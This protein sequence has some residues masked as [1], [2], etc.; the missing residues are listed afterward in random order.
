MKRKWG[1]LIAIL[2]VL[3]AVFPLLGAGLDFDVNKPT[4]NDTV[5]T[6]PGYIRETRS[7]VYDFAVEEHTAAGKHA[8][9][10]ATT[11]GLSEETYSAG[12]LIFNSTTGALLYGNGSAWVATNGSTS[13]PYALISTYSG[14]LTAAIAA[15][16]TS[17]KTLLVVDTPATLSAHTTL[18]ANIFLQFIGAGKVSLGAYNLTLTGPVYAP[19]VQV[20]DCSGA[21]RVLRGT[22]ET[23]RMVPEWWGAVADGTTNDYAAFGLALA[24]AGTTYDSAL[25]LTPGKVYM[26][27]DNLLTIPA[28][29]DVLFNAGSKLKLLNHNIAFY[30]QIQ[31]SVRPLFVYTGTGVAVTGTA[32]FTCESAWFPTPLPDAISFAD[33]NQTTI[34]VSTTSLTLDCTVPATAVLQIKKGN[35]ISIAT[36]KTLALNNAPE[37][38]IYAIFACVGTGKVTMPAFVQKY[39]DWWGAVGNGATDDAVPLQAWATCGGNLWLPFKT[40][41]TATAITVPDDAVIDGQGTLYQTDD[42]KEGFIVK[43]DV[44]IRNISITGA[45]AAYGGPNY[46][47]GIIPYSFRNGSG[48]NITTGAL[49]LWASGNRMLI[50]N[51]KFTAWDVAV[52]AGLDSTIQNCTATDNWREAFYFGGTGGRALYN[53]V[54]G[55][56]SWAIDFNGGDSQAIGNKIK[57]CGRVLADGGGIVF[58]GMTTEKPMTR[59][60]ASLNEIYDC[61]VGYGIIVLSKATDGVWGDINISL[62]K[63]DGVDTTSALFGIY[64]YVGTASTVTCKNLTVEGNVISN[65]KHMLHGVYLEGGSISGNTG[66][67]FNPAPAT[68][69]AF[70][71]GSCTRLTI[72]SNKILAV[73]AADSALRFEGANNNNQI[74]GNIGQGASVGLWWATGATGTGNALSDNDFSGCTTAVFLQAALT[75]GN[76]LE[77][78]AGY[79][80]LIPATPAVPASTVEYRNIFGYPIMIVLTGGA[81]ATT[82]VAKG[83][84]SGALVTTGITFSAVT[85]NAT[86]ILAPDE[87]IALTYAVAPTWVFYGL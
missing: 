47:V 43:D 28:A 55:C 77:R 62:N 44:A 35:I 25:D 42:T 36:T 7:D 23:V 15:I 72:N 87:Y 10:S 65:F 74:T 31:A 39:P 27:Q 17:A 16:G 22:T 19:R 20:F 5:S 18:P 33:G 29:V 70:L 76:R 84:T 14:S 52:W 41:A 38:G 57:N 83:P 37:A 69:G 81:G 71:L 46:H 63:I 32:G 53:K 56:D 61:G 30:R 51:V 86:V 8:I 3:C 21:G 48:N 58:A 50:D 79:N 6:L 2:V 13:V 80:P 64:L 49:A 9:P 67:S 60:T 66:K 78:N 24:F 85:Q 11:T 34:N 82:V 75:A 12:R 1:S 73:D 59:L 26:V 68:P 45:A 54:D 4:N 40:Y